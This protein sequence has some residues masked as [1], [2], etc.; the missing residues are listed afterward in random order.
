LD[1]AE[2]FRE[3]GNARKRP[4]WL[5]GTLGFELTDIDSL[6]GLPRKILGNKTAKPGN[7]LGSFR[8]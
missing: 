1:N 7:E 8:I 4:Y 2:R 6:T 3:T 5:A